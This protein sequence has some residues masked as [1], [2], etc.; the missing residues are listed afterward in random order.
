M[1]IH[2]TCAIAYA[3]ALALSG[4]GSA[5]GTG[6]AGMASIGAGKRCFMENKPFPFVVVAFVGAPLTQ[7][8]YGFL[9]MNTILSMSDAHMKANSPDSAYIYLLTGGV[10]GGLV[11]GLA[12]VMQ[13]RAGAAASDALAETNQGFVNFM[14]ILGVIESVALFVMIFIIVTLN[15]LGPVAASG[16]N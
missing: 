8:I 16:P 6:I 2:T 7:T 11:I 10:L 5:L 3:S 15:K 13:G 12:A 14:M 4:L 9:L 1:D